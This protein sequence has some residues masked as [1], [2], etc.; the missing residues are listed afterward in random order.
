MALCLVEAYRKGL[1]T[2]EVEN[3]IRAQWLVHAQCG[4]KAQLVCVAS[5]KAVSPFLSPTLLP[6]EGHEM[7]D[8]IVTG[9]AVF[10][11]RAILFA[12]HLA[13]MC[14]A[15]AQFLCVPSPNLQLIEGDAQQLAGMITFTCNLAENVSSKVRQLDLAKVT[16]LRGVGTCPY[17]AVF[18]AHSTTDVP[19]LWWVAGLETAMFF[20]LA[21]SFWIL[22]GIRLVES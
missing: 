7:S 20:I 19:C 2:S 4:G 6:E 1:Q 17:Q 13:L 16:W 18:C 10:G 15:H 11:G 3:V 12:H 5:S 21:V 9:P 14:A 22:H 8:S